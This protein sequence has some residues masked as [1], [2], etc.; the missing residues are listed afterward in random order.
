MIVNEVYAFIVMEEGGIES[1]P[2]FLQDGIMMPLI[3]TNLQ[4]L[5]ILRENAQ[6]IS[7]A[8]GLPMTLYRFGTR[9]KMEVI[10]P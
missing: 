9:E 8:S 2:A 5:K 7:T 4:T 3:C 1:L 6:G 10:E